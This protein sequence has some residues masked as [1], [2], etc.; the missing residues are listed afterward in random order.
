MSIRLINAKRG[1][2]YIN[3]AMFLKFFNPNELAS[4]LPEMVER[5]EDCLFLN[6]D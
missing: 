1:R 3:V 2:K 5:L 6:M 4:Y